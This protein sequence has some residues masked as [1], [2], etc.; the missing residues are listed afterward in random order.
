MG[1]TMPS[2]LTDAQSRALAM[3]ALE[4]LVGLKLSAIAGRGARRDFWDLK[5][6]LE[7]S[8]LSLQGALDAYRSKYAREDI[9]HVVRSLAYFADAEGE[10]MPLGMTEE[11]WA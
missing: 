7:L 3:L 4:D 9:G 2:A 1:R 8:G 6:L 11:V 5:A 10:P